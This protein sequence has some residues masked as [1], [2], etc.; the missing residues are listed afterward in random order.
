LK[1]RQFV[2][3]LVLLI[4]FMTWL[5]QSELVTDRAGDEPASSS[6]EPAP[7]RDV[8]DAAVT[9]N[10]RATDGAGIRSGSRAGTAGDPSRSPGSPHADGCDDAVTITGRVVL[11]DSDRAVPEARVFILPFRG[12]YR[13]KSRLVFSD[14]EGRFS[15]TDDFTGG[16]LIYAAKDNLLSYRTRRDIA[17]IRVREGDQSIG[18]LT[19]EMRAA[20]EL[21]LAVLDEQDNEP[22]PEARL[23]VRG[24]LNIDFTTNERGIARLPLAP[25][26]WSIEA[27]AAGYVPKSLALAL[28]GQQQPVNILLERGGVVTGRVTD[29]EGNPI[30]AARVT[31][32]SGEI[33]AEVAC[34]GDGV[35]QI[36][37]LPRARDFTLMVTATGYAD[38]TLHWISFAGRAEREQDFVLEAVPDEDDWE[39]RLVSGTVYGDRGPLAGANVYSGNPGTTSFAETW[40]D[41]AGRY[42]LEVPVVGIALFLTASARGYAPSSRGL[43]EGEDP[44]AFDFALEIGNRLQGLVL[45]PL[46]TPLDRVSIRGYAIPRNRVWAHK[47]HPLFDGEVLYTDEQGR[48][49]IDSLPD[50]ILLSFSAW[51]HLPESRHIDLTEQS[52]ILVRLQSMGVVEGIVLDENERPLDA[53]T[54]AIRKE[55]ERGSSIDLDQVWTRAGIRFWS[56]GGRF[57][58]DRLP[59]GTPLVLTVSTEGY[60]DQA[61]TVR[62]VPGGGDPITLIL[63]PS[64]LAIGG[65]LVGSSGQPLRGIRLLAAAYDA[66]DPLNARFTW[67]RFFRGT[68]QRKT[69]TVQEAVTDGRG[70]FVF[71]DL[72]EHANIDLIVDHPGL[73]LLHREHVHE[74]PSAIDGE[75]VIVV[76]RAATLGVYL[77]HATMPGSRRAY[78]EGRGQ[79]DYYRSITLAADQEWLELDRLPPG[80][81]VLE[82]HHQAGTRTRELVL[83]E[84]ERHEIDDL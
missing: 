60:P 4:A 83:S 81:H 27:Q 71:T 5:Q 79:T 49:A 62:A 58:I 10:G 43:G 29:R 53:F 15:F 73:A 1:R 64:G 34:D 7:D 65:R 35:Y 72:P 3:G 2:L 16:Y 70:R 37:R 32:I 40:S 54:I 24:Q 13:P 33:E 84:G 48:F 47:G 66:S 69:L 68:W 75:L 61:W 22:I 31:A 26:I 67:Q 55:E 38:Q 12:A 46:D 6:A 52:E 9:G 57:S 19:L 42:T 28:N 78:L 50:K 77:D 23:G 39:T 51:D 56:E 14:A 30:E 82:I 59:T 45:D 76:P 41:G 20:E 44:G 25:G 63:K 36:D 21:V 11:A 8:D 74:D 80:T 18:P 17:E